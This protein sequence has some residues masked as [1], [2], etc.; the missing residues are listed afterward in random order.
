MNSISSAFAAALAAGVL[1]LAPMAQAQ[2][3]VPYAQFNGWEI[4]QIKDNGQVTACEAM[5]ITGSEEGLF[6]RHDASTTGI[7]FS[8]YASAAS[9]F[10][11][12]VEMWFDGDRS[13]RM[14]YAM[15]LVPDQYTFEWRTLLLPNDEPWGEIDLFANASSI[16]FGYDTGTGWN[17]VA[18]ALSGSSRA[19][20]ETFAC[21]QNASS[22]PPAQP[23]Q[24]SSGPNV[25]YGSCKLIVAGKTY[26]DM[27]AGCPI[28]LANDG[29]GTFWINTDRENYLGQYFAEV[30]P[31]G[32]GTAGAHWN[33]EPG[34][35]HAQAPLGEGFRLTGGGCWTNGNATVCAAR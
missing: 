17:E 21:F 25:I 16:H 13:S 35:T 33:A 24:Q 19:S 34:A 32:D 12:D 11:V 18:F 8:S 5:R 4:T 20:E 6:F 22:P 27:A 23:Q 15:Q 3:A 14:T 29:T 2:Q 30:S 28:W 1:S 9:P 7:G 31:F 10:P 26:V